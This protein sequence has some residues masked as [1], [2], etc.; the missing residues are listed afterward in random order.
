[1]ACTHGER[2]KGSRVLA[3]MKI[4]VVVL[5]GHAVQQGSDSTE[6]KA[7]YPFM[8]G[9]ETDEAWMRLIKELDPNQHRTQNLS[10]NITSKPITLSTSPTESVSFEKATRNAS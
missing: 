7:S 8:Y 10:G 4:G 1:M 6:I 2:L 9:R 3:E 5:R